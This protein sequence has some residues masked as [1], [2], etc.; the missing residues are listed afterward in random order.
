MLDPCQDHSKDKAIIQSTSVANAR[1]G[2]LVTGIVM[3]VFGK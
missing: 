1:K 2:E 3:P